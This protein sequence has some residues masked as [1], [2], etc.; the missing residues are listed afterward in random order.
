[1]V[2]ATA[3]AEESLPGIDFVAEAEHCPV[4]GAPVHAQKSKRRRVVTVQAGAFVARE[5]RKRCARDSTHPVVA[6]EQLSRLVPPRQD[7]GYD[8][9]V[10]VGVA[11]YLRHR[12]REEIRTELLREHGI[13]VSNGSISNLCDRFLRRLEGLHRHRTPALR[14]AMGGGYPLHIDATSEH[15]KGGLFVCLDGW[16]GWV[17]QAVKIASENVDELRPCIEEMV[18]RFGD[19]I[20]VVRDLSAAEAGA[21]GSLRAKGIPELLC[22]YHFLGAIGKKLFDAP[23]AVLRTLLRQSKV[24]TPLRDLLRELRQHTTAEVYA[25]KYGHGRLRED[26]LALIYWVLEGEGRKDLPYPFSLPHLGFL[27]RCREA[28]QRA[29]R[30]LPLPR[31]HVERRALK[32]LSRILTRFDALPRLAWVVQPTLER[33]WQAFCELRD[34]LRL[35]DAELPRGDLRYLATR[36]FP[37]LEMA[38]LRDI[39][40]TTTA[41]HQQ[42]RKRVALSPG[43]TSAEA[44]ILQYLDRYAKHLFGHPVGHDEDGK[45]V[46]VV[47]RTNNVAEHFFGTDKQKLRRRLGRA[48]LGR[49]LEDQPA[50]AT[51]ASNLLRSDY[52]R[53]LCGSL[54]HLPAAFAELDREKLRETT[55]LQRRHRDTRLLKRIG[56]LIAD[57]KPPQNS[58]II[59]GVS[60]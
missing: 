49:D 38:R 40:K 6:S 57:E 29:E 7:Y 47:E 22:H 52:V 50:Q 58:G 20:A 35:T 23:Y 37:E 60:T 44:V 2:R 28:T 43:C 8:L 19:P 10:Q 48:N 24:R 5:V 56:A 36:E 25:G 21:V 45:I 11:R 53:V 46:S 16:R 42:I 1:V 33:A 26:L 12:Q 17:L 59:E 15:G 4:C 30:W 27:Q 13:V 18:H 32:Q 9:I 41:Y 34:I 3:G 55:P 39:E 31:S 54:E 14:A 51:L